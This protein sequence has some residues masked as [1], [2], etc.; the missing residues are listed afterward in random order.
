MHICPVYI[1]HQQS[2]NDLK[3]KPKSLKHIGDIKRF[4]VRDGVFSGKRQ[5]HASGFLTGTFCSQCGGGTCH[6]P[7]MG[8]YSPHCNP[9][10]VT[11]KACLIWKTLCYDI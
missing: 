1:L 4:I 11:Y 10:E 9:Q 2:V 3:I 5:E 8:N 6:F 7:V